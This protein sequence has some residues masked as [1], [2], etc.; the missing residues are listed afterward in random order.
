LAFFKTKN[1]L[2]KRKKKKERGGRWV[3]SGNDSESNTPNPAKKWEI[4]KLEIKNQTPHPQSTRFITQ[5]QA[6]RRKTVKNS[7]GSR[8][9][10]ATGRK[11]KTFNAT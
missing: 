4:L 8:D 11:P 7:E 3:R 1:T 10:K 5:L 6:E 9:K 2:A